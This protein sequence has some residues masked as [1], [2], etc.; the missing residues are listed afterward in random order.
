MSDL[1]SLTGKVALVTGGS[2][3][4][5]LMISRGL[6]E[7]G[8][9]VYVS[10]RKKDVCDSIA[11]E[12]SEHG[13]CLSLPG[14]VSSEE[15]ILELAGQLGESEGK[16]HVLVNNAGAAWGGPLESYPDSAWDKVMATNVKGVFNLSRAVLPMLERAGTSRDPGRIINVGSI[17]GFRVPALEN[18]AYSASKA[19]VHH[20]TRVL[21]QKLGPKNVTVNAI[22]PGPF[23]SKMMNATL[24][25]IGDDL[26]AKCPLGRLGEP[27]DMAGIAVYLAA[28]ASAYVTGQII[29][30][31]GGFSTGTW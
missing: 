29:A 5:G 13:E 1:F 11:A 21:A 23:P 17:D 2:Q 28:R 15:K 9:K 12:L 30:V 4:I 6:V 22:A 20:V 7:A 10:S 19:A 27:D 14:D 16:L 25:E 24:E 18:Y 26:R 31:D 3:G 8:A